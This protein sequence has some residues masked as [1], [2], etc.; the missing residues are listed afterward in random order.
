[1]LTVKRENAASIDLSFLLDAKHS[2]NI[3]VIK[4][5]ESG[6]CLIGF[7]GKKPIELSVIYSFKNSFA[8]V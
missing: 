2:I 3:D 7:Y 8:P 5:T 6:L 1:M 4:W